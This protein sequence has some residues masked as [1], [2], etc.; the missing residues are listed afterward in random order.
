MQPAEPVYHVGLLVNLCGQALSELDPINK[1][2]SLEWA[3]SL[4]FI[5]TS[6]QGQH[7]HPARCTSS[8]GFCTK[9]GTLITYKIKC[10]C[11]AST[12]VNYYD[13]IHDCCGTVAEVAVFTLY[14]ISPDSKTFTMYM[15]HVRPGAFVLIHYYTPLQRLWSAIQARIIMNQTALLCIIG[16]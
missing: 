13:D 6:K 11:N 3:S 2:T 8:S 10:I 12:H 5:R 16:L 4:T 14:V 9:I 7:E 15:L 1:W